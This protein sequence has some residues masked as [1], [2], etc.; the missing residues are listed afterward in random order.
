MSKRQRPR[1]AARHPRATAISSKGA[2]FSKTPI[3]L[4]LLLVGFVLYLKT[5]FPSHAAQGAKEEPAPAPEE[6]PGELAPIE[7]AAIED[8]PA[9]A[10]EGE[11]DRPVS[12][13]SA[14]IE[15]EDSSFVMLDSP[16]ISFQVPDVAVIAR[17]DGFEV[18]PRAGNDNLGMRPSD[19]GD[20]VPECADERRRPASGRRAGTG[21]RG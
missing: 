7:V 20:T 4:G 14:F 15:R 19:G 5:Y 9:P 18:R 1:K 12:S 17:N 11:D 13:G 8:E 10:G 6:E 16:P 3:Y 2:V 21:R